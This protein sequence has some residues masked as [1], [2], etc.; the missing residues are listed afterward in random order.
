MCSDKNTQTNSC[1]TNK[2]NETNK[3]PDLT[4]ISISLTGNFTEN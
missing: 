4:P 2:A 3:T 1:K